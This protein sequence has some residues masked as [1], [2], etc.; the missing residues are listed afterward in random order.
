[1]TPQA[2]EDISKHVV[3]QMNLVCGSQ[4]NKKDIN[5]GKG[6]RKREVRGEGGE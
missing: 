2:S 1:M 6:I 4:T 5:M 3:T